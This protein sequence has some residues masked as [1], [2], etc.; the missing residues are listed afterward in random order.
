M[1]RSTRSHFEILEIVTA[2]LSMKDQ[3]TERIQNYRGQSDW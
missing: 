1:P 3:A 2:Q